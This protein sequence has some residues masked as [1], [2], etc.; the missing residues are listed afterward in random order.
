MNSADGEYQ[1]RT[2]ERPTIHVTDP[3]GRAVPVIPVDAIVGSEDNAVAAFRVERSGP[4]TAVVTIDEQ[5]P[6]IFC[7][8]LATVVIPVPFDHP[9]DIGR[10]EDLGGNRAARD[11]L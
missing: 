2:H 10:Q 1:A 6:G 7:R 5:D 3:D 8:G 4:H 11:S 9:R